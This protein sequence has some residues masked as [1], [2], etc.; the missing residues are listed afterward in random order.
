M[1]RYW[2]KG[3][4]VCGW[5]RS[6]QSTERG[7]VPSAEMT[8]LKASLWRIVHTWE[9]RR[10][11]QRLDVIANIYVYS[12]WRLGGPSEG[13]GSLQDK[14]ATRAGLKH[15]KD[16]LGLHRPREGSG[17]RGS[18]TWHDYKHTAG[19]PIDCIKRLLQHL[20]CQRP[21]FIPR[22]VLKN[23]CKTWKTCLTAETISTG[24]TLVHFVCVLFLAVNVSFWAPKLSHKRLCIPFLFWVGYVYVPK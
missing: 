13:C 21:L 14:S 19:S 4:S 22:P 12:R 6:T 16:Q 18:W 23:S 15:P 17:Q 11:G 3:K 10:D 1:S 20:D 9:D 8:S 24:L 5:D 2:Y 7:G